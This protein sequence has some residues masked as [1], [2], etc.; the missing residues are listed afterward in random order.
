VIAL[1]WEHALTPD[2]ARRLFASFPNVN[3]L[4]PA[5]REA[6][7]SAI[8]DLVRQHGGVVADP[9]ITILYLAQPAR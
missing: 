5:R 4:D 2:G 1:P 9:Y 7:L 3:E 6:H 8:A